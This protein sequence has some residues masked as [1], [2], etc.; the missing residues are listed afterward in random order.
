MV[1]VFPQTAWGWQGILIPSGPTPVQAGRLRA[2][3]PG[4]RPGGLGRP[5]RR[6]CSL[7]VTCASVPSLHSKELLSDVQ[8]PPP[9]FHIVPTA[10]CPVTGHHWTVLLCLFCTLPSGIYTNW[11]DPPELPLLQ[12]EQI[13]SVL[14]IWEVLKSLDHLLFEYNQCSM[15]SSPLWTLSS[16]TDKMKTTRTTINSY[17]N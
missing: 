2:G 3:C 9:V 4:P 5:P 12:P 17:K 13:H 6:L 10:S 1:L 8:T 7:W 15:G 16:R 14:L 11:W